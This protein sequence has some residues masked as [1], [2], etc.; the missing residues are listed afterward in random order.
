MSHT[1]PS[2]DGALDRLQ[3][4]QTRR[5]LGAH[6]RD[7][8]TLAA[9]SR[10][11]ATGVDALKAAA[12]SRLSDAMHQVGGAAASTT[13]RPGMIAA[14]AGGI[15]SV[16]MA[17]IA[18]RRRRRRALQAPGTIASVAAAVLR[19]GSPWLGL[20]LTIAT[21]LLRRQR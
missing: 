13:R 21:A 3:M 18:S 14:V 11:V 16:A 12:T 2:P 7:V 15:G 9:P 17:L 6:L 20:A 8:G 1:I 19:P 4:A 5:R 10:L